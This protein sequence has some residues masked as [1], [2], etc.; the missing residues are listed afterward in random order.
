MIYRLLADVVI[1]VHV[2]FVLFVVCGG[3]LVMHWPRLAWVHGPCVLWGAAVEIGGWICPL[4]HLEN[5][6]R[7][8]GRGLGYSGGFVDHILLPLIYPDYWFEGGFP[9]W[10][11][12]M[13]GVCVLVMNMLL[14]WGV[15]QKMRPVENAK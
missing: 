3:F 12:T 11:F 9:S 8:M 2:V 14:Y 13:I 10:G 15:W 4:T 7:Q 6:W 5:H 1:V